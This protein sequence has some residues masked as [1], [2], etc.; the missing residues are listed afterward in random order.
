MW[1]ERKGV[2]GLLAAV[3]GRVLQG[4]QDA[5]WVCLRLSI[6]T[7]RT[8]DHMNGT[9]ACEIAFNQNIDNVQLQR[10]RSRKVRKIFTCTPDWKSRLAKQLAVICNEYR[11][12]NIRFAENVYRVVH[13]C[14]CF[15]CLI[16]QTSDTE[17]FG[18]FSPMWRASLCANELRGLQAVLVDYA[19][20]VVRWCAS[21]LTLRHY[22]RWLN[23]L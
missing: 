17:V 2:I 3:C 12:N 20:T 19:F 18:L 7:G 23:T 1:V 11:K 5:R 6:C 9:Y 13:L 15:V 16:E 10:S 14:G 8:I 22:E 21:D 4:F